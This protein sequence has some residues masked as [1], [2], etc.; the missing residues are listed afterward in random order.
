LPITGSTPWAPGHD[1]SVTNQ[2]GSKIKT[3]QEQMQVKLAL[4]WLLPFF[5]PVPVFLLGTAM[6]YMIFNHNV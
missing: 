5:F 1:G 6:Q 4:P 3:Q 2:K